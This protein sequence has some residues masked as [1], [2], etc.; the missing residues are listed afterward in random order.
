MGDNRCRNRL[1]NAQLEDQGVWG[2]QNVSLISIE[3]PLL[4]LYAKN[5]NKAA[6]NLGMYDVWSASLSGHLHHRTTLKA[7]LLK[8]KIP[9]SVWNRTPVV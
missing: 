4:F 9:F 1:E 6:W 8:K 2:I 7:V 3:K 5:S